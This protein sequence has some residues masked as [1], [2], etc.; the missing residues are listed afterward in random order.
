MPQWSPPRRWGSPSRECF[1]APSLRWAVL[2]L[3]K[4]L[5][6]IASAIAL[7]GV[8]PPL[9]FYSVP[10]LAPLYVYPLLG[11]AALALLWSG[12]LGLAATLALLPTGVTRLYWIIL[13]G[14]IVTDAD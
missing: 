9:D 7:G 11:V 5:A 8:M 4:A 12:R 10:I 2:L 14:A 3:V 6:A 13:A 1:R